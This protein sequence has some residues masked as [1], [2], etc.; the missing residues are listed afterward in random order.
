VPGGCITSAIE[1]EIERSIGADFVKALVVSINVLK[2]GETRFD[3][4]G[5]LARIVESPTTAR[6]QIVSTWVF[7]SSG[8]KMMADLIIQD[9]FEPY[10]AGR[11]RPLRSPSVKTNEQRSSCSAR[12]S[13]LPLRDRQKHLP[14]AANAHH[15]GTS[16]DG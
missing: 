10:Y 11:N 8:R 13:L 7:S 6:E 5:D 2:L 12:S 16:R 15:Q 4:T 14:P 9:A 1:P 3:A